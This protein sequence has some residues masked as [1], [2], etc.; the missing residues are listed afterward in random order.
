MD[1]AFTPEQ[2]ELRTSVRRAF[3]SGIVE[4]WL[5][6]LLV[7]EEHGGS[8]GSFLDAAVVLEESG[9]ALLDAP[10]L[11]TLV[12]TAATDDAA[13]SAAVV[14]GAAASVSTDRALVPDAGRAGWIVSAAADGLWVSETFTVGDPR[15]LDATRELFPVEVRDRRP[16]GD[17]TASARAVD[18]LR[19]ALSV[20]AVGV[21]RWCLETTVDYLKTREQ[22]DRPIGSFQALQH[23]AADLLV[24]L[25]SA[26]ST[27][28]YAAWAAAES[29][30]ELPVVAPLALSVCGAAAYDVAA[31]TIQLHGGI[32][33]TWEHRAHLYFKRAT[34]TRLLLGD[35]HVQRALVRSRAGMLP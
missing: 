17:E 22:F 29:P 13:L 5:P 2:E 1:F 23:R 34:A 28:Y 4:P 12:A 15:G 32:G 14:A 20:E 25:E 8:G 21:S 31:D 9:R 27:A 24:R 18:L 19:L 7:P 6:A 16:V 11:P 3:A 30:A 33:F 26:T 10:L 35:S